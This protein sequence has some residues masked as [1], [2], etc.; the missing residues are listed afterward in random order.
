[1][2]TPSPPV[3]QEKTLITVAGT[4]VA[5][6]LLV[7]GAGQTGALLH[8]GTWM[9]VPIPEAPFIVWRLATNPADPQAAWPTGDAGLLP[10]TTVFYII[11]AGLIVAAAT[12][13]GVVAW[14]WTQRRGKREDEDAVTWA[15]PKDL[16]PILVPHPKPGR[17]LPF[18]GHK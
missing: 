16:K 1:M 18:D 14:W 5:V 9:Q 17:L 11:L 8:A 15:K 2:S 7:W 12:L 10:G 3:E 4:V 6:C 13:A